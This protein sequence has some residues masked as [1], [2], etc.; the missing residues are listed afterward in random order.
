[1]GTLCDCTGHIPVKLALVLGSSVLRTPFLQVASLPWLQV[2]LPY[3]L[4]LHLDHRKRDA[5]RVKAPPSHIPHQLPRCQQLILHLQLQPM[6]RGKQILISSE[7][8]SSQ[9][10]PLPDLFEKKSLF[11]QMYSPYSTGSIEV[12]FY[13]QFV[14]GKKRWNLASLLPCTH[15]RKIVTMIWMPQNW[16]LEG[17]A[18]VIKA[19]CFYFWACLVPCPQTGGRRRQESKMALKGWGG[20]HS[21]RAAASGVN[22]DSWENFGGRYVAS[23]VEARVE[24]AMRESMFRGLDTPIG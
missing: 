5:L 2:W 1:M 15:W 6:C 3:L 24:E 10:C 14:Q 4:S 23:K 20:S 11:Y 18:V 22:R 19:A 8:L 16:L 17:E 13:A 12:G 9:N 7:K 21:V